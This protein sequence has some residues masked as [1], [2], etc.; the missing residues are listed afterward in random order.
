VYFDD[1][2]DENHT[3]YDDDENHTYYAIIDEI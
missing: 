2:D 3:Y 1:D